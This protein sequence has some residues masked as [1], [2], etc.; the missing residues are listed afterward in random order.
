M[1]LHGLPWS[2]LKT[3]VIDVPSSLENIFSYLSQCT[4]ATAVTI[5]GETPKNPGKTRLPSHRFPAHTLP[6]LTSLKLSRGCDPLWLLRHFTAPSLQQ[7]EVAILRRDQQV[8]EDFVKRSPSIHTLIIDERY[9]EDYAYADEA[10]ITDQEIIAYLT[11]PCLRAIPRVGL[12]LLYTKKRIP[13]LIQEGL[14]GGRPLPP[15]LC[16][17]PENWDQRLVGW[18]DELDPELHTLLFSYE[19]GSIELSP[20]Y[21]ID[22]DYPF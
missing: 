6:N 14:E 1:S 2:Q 15:L 8:L 16:W 19:D 10:L 17:I 7:L 11:S 3:V 9:G 18:W 13:A 22:S 12:D 5:H 4:S 21:Q 20:E